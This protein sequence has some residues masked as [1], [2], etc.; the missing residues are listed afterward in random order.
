VRNSLS[1][2]SLPS[3]I[4][5]LVLF[6]VISAAVTFWVTQASI[7]EIS[8]KLF[9]ADIGLIV[10]NAIRY[11]PALSGLVIR[12]EIIGLFICIYICLLLLVLTFMVFK[13]VKSLRRKD[14][15]YVDG[16]KLLINRAAIRDANKKLKKEDDE[17]TLKIHPAI[18]ITGQL[19]AGNIF[20]TGQSGSGKSTVFKSIAVQIYS[21]PH[22]SF[23]YDEKGE[24]QDSFRSNNSICLKLLEQAEYFWDIGKDIKNEHE[25]A[26]VAQAMI[27]EESESQRFFT[28]AARQIFKNV[29][30]SLVKSG[31]RWSWHELTKSLFSEDQQLKSL[32]LKVS[33]SAAIL[34]EPKTKTT[35][36]I[37]SVL[38]TQLFW[39]Q[40]MAEMQTSASNSWCI[41]ELIDA[42]TNKTH[43]F[44]RPN[45]TRPDLSKSVC[46]AII[47]LIIE[48]WLLRNDN[49][50]EKLFLLIDEMGN[51]PYNPSILRW[52][53][54]SRSKGGRT[55]AST[56][57]IGLLYE[58]YGQ[59]HTDTILSLFRTNIV[60]RLGASGPS[61]QKASDLFGQQRVLTINQSLDKEQAITIS[62]Q[63][64]DRPVVPREEIVN[65]PSAD[66]Y[67]VFGFLFI[68]GFTNVYKL[69]WSYHIIDKPCKL[70][71]TEHSALE[72]QEQK[73][74]VLP[75]NR[76]N[77]RQT[78]DEVKNK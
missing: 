66:K 37:R 51:L 46:N 16:P 39:L 45:Y 40:E 63:Y 11:I 65:L 55:M 73:I 64:H 13:Y 57:E 76:L 41:G 8:E 36:S 3:Y 34:I 25:A 28:D 62:T 18:K 9:L 7:I 23:T 27:E 61:A 33:E 10:I 59:N 69:R 43:V 56:Q 35:Q 58:A 26:L 71:V 48:R 15:K 44:F 70:S 30:I 47:T 14:Y 24:Y 60:M 4:F 38:S 22:R 21:Q 49:S 78:N 54:L 1:V 68:G 19:E 67:G 52:L 50:E 6:A 75:E 29:I 72:I 77:K 17:L 20:L 2:I 53:T 31:E 74:E 12:P 42:N 32:L 5:L